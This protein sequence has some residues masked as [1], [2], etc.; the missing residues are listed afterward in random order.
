[1]IDIFTEFN[2]TNY[3]YNRSFNIPNILP[4][5]GEFVIQPNELSYHKSFNI[6]LSYLYDNFMYLY[7]RCSMPNYIIPTTFN[8]F[9]GVTGSDI[10]IYQ[11]TSL[12][13]FFSAAN[14]SDLDNAKNA[15]VYKNKDLYYLFINC[16]SS[17][18]IIYYNP[19]LNFA[20]LCAYKVTTVDPI[21]GDLKF[22]R[23]NSLSIHQNKFLYVSDE[24]LDVV[25]K[26]DLEKFFSE[27]N[28]YKSLTYP[29][30]NNLFLLNTVGTEGDRYDPIRFNKPQKIATYDD[31]VLIEDYNNK[32]V[33]LYNS[34]LDFLSYRSLINLYNTVTSFESIKFI[35]KE[36]LYF[37]TTGGFY[38]FNLNPE[39]YQL[40]QST[41]TSLTSILKNKERVIDIEKCK[42]ES[43][44]LYILTDQAL[45]KK[46]D[47]IPS[48]TIGRL[49]AS[50]FGN[51]SFFKWFYTLKDTVSSDRI[52]IYCYNSTANANQILVYTDEFDLISILNDRHF[53]IFSKEEVLVKKTEWNQAWVYNKSLRKMGKNI[54]ILKNMLSY[55][56]F[57]NEDSLGNIVLIKKIYDTRTLTYSAFN[58]DDY[59]IVGIN[60]NFQTSVINREFEKIYNLESSLLNI[61]NEEVTSESPSPTGFL[62][63]ITPTPTPTLSP[64][65]TTTPTNTPTYTPSNTLTPTNTPTETPT[66][67]QTKTPTTPTPTPTLTPTQ[68]PTPTQT[69]T[70][71]NN[72][73]RTPTPTQTGTPTNT[74]T[75]TQTPTDTPVTPTP[76][77]TPTTTPVL[78]YNWYII[79]E[80]DVSINTSFDKTLTYGGDK[81]LAVSSRIGDRKAWYSTNGNT[82]TE[83][84]NYSNEVDVRASLVTY[85][86]DKFLI[87]GASS[88]FVYY[89]SD[90]VNFTLK[91][92]STKGSYNAAL[93]S[94]LNGGTLFA[95]GSNDSVKT[96][97]AVIWSSIPSLNAAGNGYIPTDIAEGNGKIVVMD[98]NGPIYSTDGITWNRASIGTG[99]YKNVVF[100]QGKFLTINNTNYNMFESTNGINWQESNEANGG[101]K[102]TVDGVQ[103]TGGL[104]SGIINKIIY[105]NNTFIAIGEK[106]LT[107]SNGINWFTKASNYFATMGNMNSIAYGNGKYIVYS[108]STTTSHIS[109]WGSG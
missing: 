4:Y 8:G 73:T 76:T 56:F 22:Q 3:D 53:D 40:T 1:M 51:G 13:N 20:S 64:T 79:K 106:I 66:P 21:S 11:N 85:F 31:Y 15:I 68:T 27:E 46:W 89:T 82:W 19:T 37:S 77:Q 52:Y 49:D 69:E 94:S 45:I 67:T 47:Q 103:T 18:N 5:K 92:L 36:T 98:G 17:I 41:F 2:K 7:S 90:L 105:E 99:S 72:I 54:D 61:I 108:G 107:S 32:I 42:Y 86:K 63:Y 84:A 10:N 91:L 100:G 101:N 33:K 39:S 50:D 80:P 48:K 71:F 78:G 38:Q 35:D 16:V 60:E 30:E 109:G 12:S 97:D 9:I 95:V 65:N 23:I 43:N 96:T 55:K 14:A 34:N 75:Q 44:I 74:L 104:G 26:Y 29:Y 24:V 93:S 102:V 88:T 6:K 58:Y 57:L 62:A 81:F 87:F 59:F 83:V 25:Y 28:I 70:P